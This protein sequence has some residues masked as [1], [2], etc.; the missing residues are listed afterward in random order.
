MSLYYTYK[1]VG[2]GDQDFARQK[3]Q[4]MAIFNGVLGFAALQAKDYGKARRHYSYWQGRARAVQIA[5]DYGVMGDILRERAAEAPDRPAVI[6]ETGEA[7]TY[8][9][10]DALADRAANAHSPAAAIGR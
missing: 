8:A 7:V 5:A 1:P 4:V 3:L 2:M 9:A 6:M 10:F